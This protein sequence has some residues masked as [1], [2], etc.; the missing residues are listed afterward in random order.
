MNR[1]YT[2]KGDSGTTS[3][4]DGSRISKAHPRVAAYGKA[5]ELTAW[6]GLIRSQAEFPGVQ[7]LAGVAGSLRKIQFHMM[8]MAGQ[9]ASANTTDTKKHDFTSGSLWL[10][11]AI[12]D[13]QEQIPPLSSFTLPCKPAISA[14]IHIARTICRETE[15]HMVS[16]G[17]DVVSADMLTY[18]NRLSDYLFVLARF[19]TTATGCEE[20]FFV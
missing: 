15:R 20:D 19:I 6:I 13:M 2:G 5:D 8:H 17:T 3:L 7:K 12:D 1:I 9:L 18:I 16:L 4:S 11:K 10:E 14:Q